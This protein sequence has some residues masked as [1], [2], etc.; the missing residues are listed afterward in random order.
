VQKGGPLRV[1]NVANHLPKHRV[2]EAAR[3]MGLFNQERFRIDLGHDIE[4]SEEEGENS[5]QE[6]PSGRS[7]GQRGVH[8]GGGVNIREIEALTVR[9]VIRNV[10]LFGV[11]REGFHLQG[12]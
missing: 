10:L 8:L 4:N 2:V 5:L 11:G 9:I 6:G 7:S 1:E 3:R 12:M